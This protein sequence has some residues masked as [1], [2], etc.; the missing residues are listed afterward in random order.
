M[1][2]FKTF[3]IEPSAANLIE[4]I[5]SIGYSFET[6]ISD[7]IDN[8]ISAKAKDIDIY[9]NKENYEPYIQIIDNGIGMLVDELTDAMRL[10]SINPNETRDKEDLGR[11]GLGL[12]SASFS[13]CRNLTVISKKD[14]KLNALKW[15]LDYIVETNSFNVI[16]LNDNQI[17]QIPNIEKLDNIESG[18]IVMWSNF[19][20]ISV[21]S[22][23]LFDELSNLMKSAIDHIALIFHRYLL[24]SV[25]ISV[26]NEKIKPKDPFL[27]HH[28]GTQQL[29]HKRIIVDGEAIEVTPYVLPHYSNLSFEDKLLS[30][31]VKDH[32]KNQ[33]FYLYRNNRLIVWGDYLGLNRKSELSKNLRIRVDLPNSLDYLW[34]IDIKKSQAKVPSK[35]SKNLLSAISDGEIV[36]RKV[37]TY[38][39][40]NEQS[41]VK[42]IWKLYTNRSSEFFLEIDKSN[43]LYTSL[44]N[45]LNLNQRRLFDLLVKSME[46]NI[47]FQTIY[48][49]V[50]SGNQN[51]SNMDS[52]LM[53]SVMKSLESIKNMEGTDYVAYLKSLI[54]IEPYRNDE[55][56]VEYL[57]SE[58]EREGN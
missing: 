6:A 40:K 23:D 27:L 5:R 1:T 43:I 31:K 16:M 36:S 49:E 50:A 25:L 34:D 51:S 11:F 39:G 2:N 54:S 8:S 56:L 20:R 15:D 48:A 57:N 38:R 55:K 22:N 52:D 29:Q 53:K 9:L 13:V 24:K 4:S 21:T 26:N 3:P 19:D 10:G 30:G 44:K 47:P 28:P 58:I 18:T 37:N 45:S 32:N 46:D 12:K 35:I 14:S 33:G 7:I 17:S 42:S 41:N